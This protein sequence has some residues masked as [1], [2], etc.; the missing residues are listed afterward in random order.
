MIAKL[1]MG[2]AALAWL[3]DGLRIPTSFGDELRFEITSG[4]RPGRPEI[5]PGQG[6][7][8]CP[9]FPERSC[10]TDPSHTLPSLWNYQL[11]SLKGLYNKICEHFQDR[12]NESSGKFDL[13][14]L[15]DGTDVSG[16]MLTRIGN[17]ISGPLHG[18][19]IPGSHVE[20]AENHGNTNIKFSVGDGQNLAFGENTF[21][22]VISSYIMEHVPSPDLYF[23]NIHKILKTGGLASVAWGPSWMSRKG[24]H[25]HEDMVEEW[26]RSQGVQFTYRND[27]SIIPDWSHLV[28]NKEE[29]VEYLVQKRGMPQALA[30]KCGHFIYDSRDT[31][32]VPYHMV[33]QAMNDLPGVSEFDAFCDPLGKSKILKKAMKAMPDVPEESFKC[34]G[35]QWT[36]K[37]N[38]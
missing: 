31:N 11:F 18:I 21:D 7:L 33:K 6:K 26:A 28:W 23:K 8:T 34:S 10:E 14:I 38:K 4:Q 35:G 30:E 27:G 25:I 9:S 37:K 1:A 19:N 17:C 22:V 32:H 3:A 15:D 12:F 16:N 24:H 36:Y 20:N 13:S 29:M 5:V 2:I